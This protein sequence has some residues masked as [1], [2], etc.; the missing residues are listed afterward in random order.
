MAQVT[1]AILDGRAYGLHRPQPMGCMA[2]D[3]VDI[4]VWRVDSPPDKL[5]LK[6]RDGS[7]RP[8]SRCS[9]KGAQEQSLLGETA[10]AIAGSPWLKPKVVQAPVDILVCRVD[11]PLDRPWLKEGDG[12]CRPR[13]R[14][15]R[16]GAQEQSLLGVTVLAVAGRLWL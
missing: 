13:S 11:T 14:C 4:L 9:R 5:W 12:S 1:V 16:K 7:C 3:S 15:S 6:M 10:L 2:Q 8:R